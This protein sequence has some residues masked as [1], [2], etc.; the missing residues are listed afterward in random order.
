MLAV[1]RILCY[2]EIDSFL[3]IKVLLHKVWALTECICKSQ[4]TYRYGISITMTL[5]RAHTNTHTHTHTIHRFSIIESALSFPSVFPTSAS[6]EI[7][8]EPDS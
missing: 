6:M 7:R 8:H 2:T 1:S 3:V 5:S 4:V